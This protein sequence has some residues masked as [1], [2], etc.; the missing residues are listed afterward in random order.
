M[1]WWEGV[2][3]WAG[4]CGLAHA[5]LRR[6]RPAERHKLVRIA[7]SLGHCLLW[8]GRPR[9]PPLA[10]SAA[11]YLGD[12]LHM[13]LAGGGW[14]PSMVAHHALALLLL[15]HALSLPA[16]AQFRVGVEG[17]F[18]CA[19]MS[20]LPGCVS[21]ACIK[22]LGRDHPATQKALGAQLLVYPWLRTA[23]ITRAVRDC[24]A[25]WRECPAHLWPCWLILPMGWWWSLKLCSDV[26]R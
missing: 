8:A 11:Y 25:L 16:G 3:L 1:S 15:Q 6:R 23:R 24:P 13:A 10:A 21:Y 7:A 5:L 18:W 4:T 2:A 20:N 17:I 19:E 26:A 12:L 9:A 14:W 22:L